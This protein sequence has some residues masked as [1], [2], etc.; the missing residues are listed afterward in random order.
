MLEDDPYCSSNE[1]IDKYLKSKYLRTIVIE[2]HLNMI[3]KQH[4]FEEEELY[5]KA[6]RLNRHK[7]TDA[8]WRY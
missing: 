6:I 7:M 3:Q 8:G 4:S 5:L 2:K 1:E